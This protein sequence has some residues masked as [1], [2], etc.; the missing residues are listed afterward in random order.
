MYYDFSYKKTKYD[1]RLIFSLDI[2]ISLHYNFIY[3]ILMRTIKTLF[4]ITALLLIV[5]CDN[6][7]E[8]KKEM[9]FKIGQIHDNNLGAEKKDDE[10]TSV[11]SENLI[12]MSNKGIGP[13]KN[14]ELGESI[15]ESMAKAGED[16]FN[17]LCLACHK[18]TQKFLGPAPLGVLERRSPEWVMNM[19]MNPA[20]MIQDDPIAK[21]LVVESNGAIMVDM[22]VTED[23]ARELV[24]YFRTLKAKS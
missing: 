17:N 16:L 9:R 11:S 12:D 13:V 24:E 6:K 19:I 2:V 4:A 7:N 10:S 18:P 22:G 3:A 15:D 20:E 8:R 5:S 23:E 1:N 21:Q 14:V